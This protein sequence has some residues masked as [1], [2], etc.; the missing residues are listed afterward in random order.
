MKL[1]F[2]LSILILITVI[3]A[4][5]NSDT[6]SP[7]NEIL[8]QPPYLALTDSIKDNS[9]NDNLYF[10]RAVLLRKNELKE[11]A[12]A[13]F[14]K[15]WSL[16]GKEEY[17]AN[18]SALLLENKPDSAIV[19]INGA[20]QKIPSSIF[21]KLD[22]ARAYKN[23]NEKE[24]ALDVCRDIIEKAPGQIDALMMQS[25][26]LEEKRDSA[27]SVVSLEKA[28]TLAPFD[29]ELN[30]NL[31]FKYAQ[32]RNPKAISLCDS[33][34][35]KDSTHTHAEPYYFKG[36]YYYNINEKDKAISFFSQAIQHDY[37]FLDAYL[38]KGRTLYE[39]KKINEALKV[40]TLAS[41]VSPAYADAYYWIGKCLQA[42][43]KKDEAKENYQR[44]YGFD[45][46]LTEAKDSA[47][48]IK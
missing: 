35:K 10:R 38:D 42:S 2:K 17:A 25:E 20:L 19:F 15:A 27:G 21:L 4:C 34:L 8:R 45:K 6:V 3:A 30:Y 31:A 28:Y 36:V 24:K 1:I 48:K 13:D 26:L 9:G 18:I 47:D 23:V 16:K 11:P 44:A 14:Q 7:Y 40:F 46:T 29:L 32:N 33:L 37:N 12:L 5:N 41:T 39:Q 43:G 22:L